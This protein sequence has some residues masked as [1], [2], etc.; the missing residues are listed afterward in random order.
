MLVRC[1]WLIVGCCLAGSAAGGEISPSVSER[2]A[3]LGTTEAPSFQR[4]VLPLLGR[5]GCNGRACHGSFQGRGGFRLSLFGY[6]FAA[7]HAAILGGDEPRVNLK[8]PL[9]SLILQ[10][11]TLVIDHEGGQRIKP[12]SWEHRLVLKWIE[13]GAKP[14]REDDPQFVS[15]VVEPQEIVFHRV[16]QSVP[17]KLIARWSDGAMEDVTSLC[18]FQTN[19]ESVATVDEA[20]KITSRGKGDTHVVAFY[21]NGVA[22]VPVLLPVSDLSGSRYPKVPAPTRLDELV[23]AKLRQLGIV[24]S[25]L[26]SD[27]DFLRRLSLD[28]T[29]SLPAPQEVRQF[30]ADGKSDKRTRK[31]DE[32]LSRPAYAAWWTTRLTDWM[33]NGEANGP[34][35]GEQ[36]LR[37]RFAEQWYFWTYRRVRENMPYDQLV[38]G[39]I[40]ATSRQP[41]QSY[42]DYCAQMSSYFR[43]ED[44]A[45]FATRPTMPYYWTRRSVGKPEDKALAFAYSFL[46]VRLECSQCHKHP[47]DQWTKQD[48]DQFAAF[49]N[50]VRYGAGNRAQIQAMKA[51]AELAGLDE[52]SGQYKRKFVDLLQQGQVLP[53]KELSVP[54]NQRKPSPAKG[55]S[56]LKFGRVITARLLGG[57]EVLT[58][59]YDDPR[60]PLVDWLRQDDNPY[61]ARALVN[62][63]WANYFNV[64]LIDPPDDMNLANPPSNAPL[65]D[66]LAEEFVAHDYDLRWLNREIVSSRTYQLDWQPNETNVVD[67]L[68]FSH[69]VVRRLP[70]EVAYDALVLATANDE[71]RSRLVEDETIVQT[72]AIGV[73]SG[74]AGTREEGQYAVNLFGKPARAVN[75]DCERANEPSLL[76]TVYLQNDGEIF[77][78]LDRKDGWLS[79][80]VREESNP[81]DLVDDAYLR[82]L[83]RLPNDQERRIA[84]GYLD[85]AEN[86]R[87][88]LRT[89]LWALLNTKEFILNH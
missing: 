11:P 49:F 50:G 40:L 36:G 46:G 48:F 81:K 73:S 8:A 42:D 86:G 18:R 89:L 53:F 60:R 20:G 19:D 44:P 24:P 57:E 58:Y 30:L 41:D 9:E 5:L 15:L 66:W 80:A 52:D 62:R 12:D 47:Y 4:H 6:D 17:L 65:L 32:L 23:V 34:V 45:D 43:K 85:S 87:P 59:Q 56:D 55:K 35:G 22:P 38:A 83:S 14:A 25:E 75:C 63:V 71:A 13:A 28:L 70:A 77:R 68:N 78:K 67:A 26:C 31:I 61:F 27:A 2:F 29:G 54:Q 10:K 76:Q 72:R 74:Y 33:G 21:D 88:G 37:R 64:G 51:S 16:G 79:Q 3:R 7:D 82:T 69:S 1:L 39:I 84:L